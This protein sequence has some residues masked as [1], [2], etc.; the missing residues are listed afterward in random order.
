MIA[1]SVRPDAS[2]ASLT[3]TRKSGW[4]SES[5][6]CSSEPTTT[7]NSPEAT[8]L[9][10]TSIAPVPSAKSCSP[11]SGPRQPS[12]A[13]DSATPASRSCCRNESSPTSPT[14]AAAVSTSSHPPLHERLP[15]P[16]P[17]GEQPEQ[18]CV[19][20]FMGSQH[21]ENVISHS[22]EEDLVA[23]RLPD[24]G[25]PVPD[26]SGHLPPHGLDAESPSARQSTCINRGV[27]RIEPDQQGL[28]AAPIMATCQNAT[29][30][31][32]FDRNRTPS[33]AGRTAFE[34]SPRRMQGVVSLR[35]HTP[36]PT[37]RC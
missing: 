19:T 15:C 35:S 27:G 21:D 11:S 14:S 8:T 36:A 31:C 9:A 5:S 32:S 4:T 2:S 25:H 28:F 10:F 18:R 1:G 16:D 6:S 12:S 17:A 7:G 23:G 3:P 26:V 34:R 13:T 33:L 20:P 30:P 22:G 37:A 29:R 24:E